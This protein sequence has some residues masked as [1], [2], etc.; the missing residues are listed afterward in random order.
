MN[1]KC[2][3]ICI[4]SVFTNLFLILLKYIHYYVH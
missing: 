4:T 3:Y 1:R 2:T